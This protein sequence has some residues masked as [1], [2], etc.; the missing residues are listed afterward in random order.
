[1]LI[2]II[3]GLFALFVIVFSFGVNM[4][5]EKMD[6]MQDEIILLRQGQDAFRAVI[7]KTPDQILRL[8]E[9]LQEIEKDLKDHKKEGHR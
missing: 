8:K 1:M 9:D 2:S 5:L 3:G 4:V 7:I 6:S